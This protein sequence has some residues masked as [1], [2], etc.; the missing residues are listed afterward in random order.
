[1]GRCEP[2][3]AFTHNCAQNGAQRRE[4][5]LH[6]T[7]SNAVDKESEETLQALIRA[8]HAHQRPGLFLACLQGREGWLHRRLLAHLPESRLTLMDFEGVSVDDLARELTL[9]GLH[10]AG[11]L[12]V[13]GGMEFTSEGLGRLVRWPATLA[14]EFAGSVIVCLSRAQ[15]M[16][17]AQ[18]EARRLLSIPCFYFE[19][20]P[21]TPAEAE[22]RGWHLTCLLCGHDTESLRKID[23]TPD[24]KSDL[25]HMQEH[26]RHWHDVDLA[27]LPHCTRRDRYGG[28]YI[29]QLPDGRDWLLAR[30]ETVGRE[31]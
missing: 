2:Q 6:V 19:P 16:T 22:T 9:E 1:M 15:F 30:P 17:L 7:P 4:R 31:Q 14:H 28:G 18:E 24:G 13:V 27:V 25:V 10:Q 11:G 21:S 5:A 23:P 26:L 3:T 12:L 8:L 29:W 20:E